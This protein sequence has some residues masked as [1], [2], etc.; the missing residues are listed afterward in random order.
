MTLKWQVPAGVEIVAGDCG[1]VFRA[2]GEFREVLYAVSEQEEPLCAK[3]ASCQTADDYSRFICAHGVPIAD[4]D[5]EAELMEM[6]AEEMRLGLGALTA[7]P[8]DRAAHARQLAQRIES[9][10]LLGIELEPG[11]VSPKMIATVNTLAEFLRFEIL[12]AFE[13][14]GI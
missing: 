8:D 11:A 9:L 3:L 14:A 7:N 1:R 4:E 2:A 10:T 5:A 13:R 6:L 12:R